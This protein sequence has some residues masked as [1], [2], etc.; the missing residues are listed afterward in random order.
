VRRLCGRGEVADALDE[1]TR[2]LIDGAG[3]AYC[4]DTPLPPAEATRVNAAFR[5]LINAS[6]VNDLVHLDRFFVNGDGDV[7]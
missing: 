5:G 3:E 7:R 4:I 6:D 1:K 2:A